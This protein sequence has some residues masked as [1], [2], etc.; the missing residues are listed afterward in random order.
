MAI[1]GPQYESFMKERHAW[2]WSY[3]VIDALTL[4]FLVCHLVFMVTQFSH[5]E[6][7]PGSESWFHV[8]LPRFLL[9]CLCQPTSFVIVH[10]FIHTALLQAWQCDHTVVVPWGF[11]H[12]YVDPRMYSRTPHCYRLNFHQWSVL[13]AAVAFLVGNCCDPAYYC[14]WMLVMHF[15]L[16]IHEWYRKIL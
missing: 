14:A 13:A 7:Y 5:E 11:Y 12:H 16:E 2:E 10:I 4:T 9:A 1:I 6:V 15:D 3:Q 8:L